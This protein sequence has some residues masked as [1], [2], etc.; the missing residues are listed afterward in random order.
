MPDT[1]LTMEYDVAMNPEYDV[2]IVGYGPAG[3]SL[4]NL[5]GQAGLSVLVLEKDAAIY[6]LPRAIHFDGEVMRV[7]QAM[8]LRTAVEAISRP[9]TK[10]MHF[11]NAT[12]DTLLVRGGTSLNGPHGCANNY[13]F[14]QPELEQ[15][16]R[17]GV[18]RFVNVDVQLQ[19]EVTRIV[20]G[21]DH[22]RLSVADLRDG[23]SGEV[24][25]IRARYV[26][27]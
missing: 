1:A 2:A 3:A 19:R 7:F 13:Y 15:V 4:A 24:A 16:L 10:G 21:A 18:K 25:D 8:G 12:G 5:L 14:H 11:V 23:H 6:P 27:G 20:D 26:V 9:G 17:D 22:V